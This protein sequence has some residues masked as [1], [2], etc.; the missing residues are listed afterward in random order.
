M[1]SN[2]RAIHPPRVLDVRAAQGRKER[3]RRDP[4]G[5]EF[6][7]EEGEEKAPP[8]SDE[9]PSTRRSTAVSN[10]QEDEA[11]ARLDLTA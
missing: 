8:P 6:E 2:V 3:P 10:R 4:S 7:V 5:K 1:E 11:G 9:A